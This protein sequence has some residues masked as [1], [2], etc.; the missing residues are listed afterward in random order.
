A[1]VVSLVPT[2]GASLAATTAGMGCFKT[3][4]IVNGKRRAP[5]QA[6]IAAREKSPACLMQPVS[7]AQMV[8]GSPQVLR[9]LQA[10]NDELSWPSGNPLLAVPPMPPAK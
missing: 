9:E 6:L 5:T 7:A 8:Y 1:C 10:L 2:S 3:D 4:A